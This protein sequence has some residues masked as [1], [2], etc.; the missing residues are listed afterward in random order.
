[1]PLPDPFK[2]EQI[3]EV[4]PDNLVNVICKNKSGVCVCDLCRALQ[5]RVKQYESLLCT[6]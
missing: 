2:A 1:M 5:L 4:Y 6:L 3:A